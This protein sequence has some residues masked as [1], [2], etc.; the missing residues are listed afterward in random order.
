M[1]LVLVQ[2]PHAA[3][4]VGT[5]RVREEVELALLDAIFHLATSAV[6]LFVERLG[7][8]GI[9]LQRG[10]DEARVG[11]FVAA[12]RHPLR[13]GDH[14]PAAVPAVFRCP[15]EVG[16]AALRLAGCFGVMLCPSEFDG[17]VI[18][19]TRV[20]GEA[21]EVVDA[22]LLTPSMARRPSIR[23]LKGTGPAGPGGSRGRHGRSRCRRAG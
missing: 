7:F 13:L 23:S 21:E 9:C 12:A 22:V 6:E 16:E 10:H 3:G 14:P 17:D 15:A 11:A 5:P 18:D 2:P 20:A 4:C 19:E 8:P 1:V